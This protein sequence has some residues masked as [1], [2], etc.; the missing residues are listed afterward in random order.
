MRLSQE[1]HFNW[2]KKKTIF[3]VGGLIIIGLSIFSYFFFFQNAFSKDDVSLEISGPKEMVSGKNAS[4]VV[5][6]YNQSEVKIENLDLTFEYPSGVFEENGEIKKREQKEIKELLPGEKKTES[7]SGIIFGA[8]EEI[9]EAKAFLVYS[10]Q[11][12][13]TK[14]ENQTS[15][16]TRVSDTSIVFS[17]ELPAKANSDE[18]FSFSLVWQSGFDFPLKNVQLWLSLPEE[19]EISSNEAKIEKEPGDAGK[20][21]FD[22]GVLNEGEG[23]RKDIKGKIKGKVGNEKFFRADFGIFDEKLY[24]FIPLI[25]LEKSIK[26][27]TSTLDVFLKVNGEGNYMASSGERLS[28]IVDFMNTGEDIY[29]NLNLEIELESN[30]L[31]FSTIKASSGKIE[32]KKIMFSSE[33]F[34]DLLFLGPYGKSSVGFS[35]KIKDYDS[36]FHPQNGLIKQKITFGTIEKEFQT[37]ISSKISFSENIYYNLPK[38]LDEIEAS[39]KFP[40]EIGEE[41]DLAVWWNVENMGNELSDVKIE[42]VLPEGVSFTGKVFPEETEFDFDEETR[43]LILNIGNISAYAAAPEIFAVQVKIIPEDLQEIIVDKTKITGKD[44]WTEKVFEI[45]EAAKSIDLIQ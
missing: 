5:S 24:E 40:L 11:K 16:S 19:F 18:E 36:S 22:L 20:M 41:T 42:T 13:S 27:T 28:F 31:D 6:L 37:K 4:W 29:R 26:I 7:F 35:A 32:G 12:L 15:F 30:A 44:N 3:F 25:S 34:S 10:P 21:I 38:P 43:K 33:S 14:F 9:K 2:T 45:E 8:K 23:G 17:L 1:I 39:G